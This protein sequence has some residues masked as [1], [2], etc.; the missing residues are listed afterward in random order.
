MAPHLPPADLEH[1]SLHTR[2]LWDEMRNQRIF[3]TGGTGFFGCWLV[4]SFAH[5]NRILKLEA[6]ATVLT[7][8]PV[9]FSGKCP[10]IASD[11]AISLL[12]GDVRDF[13]YPDQEFRY[14]IHAATDTSA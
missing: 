4:E 3:I 1:I 5:V 10:H 12:K 8:D 13:S 7:R 2:D 9:A 6:Q 14:V 11:P